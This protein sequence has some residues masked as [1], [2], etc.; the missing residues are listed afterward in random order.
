MTFNIKTS[1]LG[2]V[3]CALQLAA[4]NGILSSSCW[5]LYC[6]YSN[7]FI[8]QH[9]KTSFASQ[10]SCLAPANICSKHA[11]FWEELRIHQKILF[12]LKA[13]EK[14]PCTEKALLSLQN[15]PPRQFQTIFSVFLG[16]LTS[17]WVFHHPRVVCNKIYERLAPWMK[18]SKVF[19]VHQTLRKPS[20]ASE[21]VIQNA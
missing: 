4:R 11:A 19:V 15:L 18:V 12:P 10:T 8:T 9:M 13:V 17:I 2:K 5:L 7:R 20:T 6:M 16:R 1:F 21:W 3:S 14:F